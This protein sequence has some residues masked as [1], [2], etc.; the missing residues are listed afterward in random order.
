M[1]QLTEDSKDYVSSINKYVDAID[2]CRDINRMPV[3]VQY[4]LETEQLRKR[5]EYLNYEQPSVVAKLRENNKS[6]SVF[7]TN[8][9]LK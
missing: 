6:N 9:V 3:S 4:I 7:L 1:Q 8:E 5:N 2:S